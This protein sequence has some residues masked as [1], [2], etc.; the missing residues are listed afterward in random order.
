MEGNDAGFPIL[1]TGTIASY[2]IL[3]VKNNPT[4]LLGFE[5][6][7][8]NSGGPV[9]LACHDR[10]YGGGTHGGEIIHGIMGI[11][12]TDVTAEEHTEQLRETRT[13]K[14]SLGLSQVVQGEF[15][16]ELVDMVPEP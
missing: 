6:F 11:V 15:I 4:F 1:R 12:V 5:V 3:P 2:P 14:T 7:G 8:G 13:I 16:K 9:Y 10:F